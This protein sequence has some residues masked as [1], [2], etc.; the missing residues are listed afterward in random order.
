MATDHAKKQEEKIFEGTTNLAGYKQMATTTL[1]H[2]KKRPVSTSTSDV[3]LDGDWVDPQVAAAAKAS[4]M[5]RANECL[6]SLDI[7]QQL[8][9]PLPDLL[10][11]QQNN[12]DDVPSMA[13]EMVGGIHACDR[14]GKDYMIKAILEKSDL[15]ACIYHTSRIRMMK[16]DGQKE[17]VYGCCED[18]LGSSGCARGPHVYKD[19]D[20]RI[21]HQKTPYVRT[22]KRDANHPKQHLIALDCEM[23]YT[24]AGMELIRFTAVDQNMHI[25]LDELVLPSNMIIDLNS[26]YSGIKTLQGVKYDLDGVRKEL[27][28][29]VDEDTI[30]VGH[31]LENDMNAMRI[32]HTKII[33]TV[34]VSWVMRWLILMSSLILL[35]VISS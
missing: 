30:I 20:M 24:T 33:D 34:A 13:H 17:K 19:T 12:D 9:Y 5:E 21:L 32:I 6:V 27:F 10:D 14:C 22:P 11:E 31:G 29:H 8:E 16:V 4:L 28:K 25:L 1:M 18:P 2:L 3:G 35:L 26:H 7:L 23:G 15:E